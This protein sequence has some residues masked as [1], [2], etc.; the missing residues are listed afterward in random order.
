M[1]KDQSYGFWRRWIVIE[2]PHGFENDPTFFDRTFTKDE[3][4]GVITVSILAFARVIQQKKFDFED[5]SADIK[6]K[7]ERASD[8]VYA[9]VSE[10]FI[11]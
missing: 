7:W 5:S 9:S 11:D 3:I 8:S 4:E 6:E 10:K 1:V 2:F